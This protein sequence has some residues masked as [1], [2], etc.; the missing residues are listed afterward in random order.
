MYGSVLVWVDPMWLERPTR[1]ISGDV[2][3]AA[4]ASPRSP[5][6][7]PNLASSWPVATCTWVSI[8]TPGLIRNDTLARR[9]SARARSDADDLL[10]ALGLHGVDAARSSAER[11]IDF[12]VAFGDAAEHDPVWREPGLQN[13]GE[14]TARNDVGAAAFGKNG[15]QDGGRGVGLGRVGDQVKRRLETP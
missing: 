6:A 7:M 9:P 10:D 5:R 14:L 2:S 8:C 3:M 4:Y 15:T 11:T 13:E 12:V 1:S